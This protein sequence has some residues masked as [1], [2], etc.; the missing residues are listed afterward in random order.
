MKRLTHDE[1][2]KKFDL[3]SE[4]KFELLSEYINRRTNIS[5]LHVECGHV[6]PMTPDAFVNQK[7]GCPNCRYKNTAKSLVQ[8]GKEKNLQLLVNLLGDEY[9]ILSEYV[10]AAKHISVKHKCCG[11]IYPT[12]PNHIK[13]GSRCYECSMK[14]AAARRIQPH[15]EFLEK[16]NRIANGEYELLSQYAGKS[17]KIMVRHLKCE[18]EYPTRPYDFLG[19]TGCP[20]CNESK[21]ERELRRIF[22]AYGVHYQTQYKIEGCKNKRKLPFDFAIFN[23]DG[24]LKMLIEYQGI[25][26]YKKTGYFKGESKLAY[27]QN[28]DRIK[29]EFCKLN[30]IPFLE[31]PYSVN[32]IEGFLQQQKIL[33]KEVFTHVRK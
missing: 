20:K 21:G 3:V 27:T 31:I 7:Q 30:G 18:N 14:A 26:H 8:I 17:K 10:G 32:S 9:E 15:E 24:S 29:R 5:I 6:F 4:G 1:F 23:E 28:N 11:S 25:Q 33:M 22:D 12:T 13:S 2:A 16:F 19:G